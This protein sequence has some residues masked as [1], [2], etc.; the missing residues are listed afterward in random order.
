MWPTPA[1]EASVASSSFIFKS[2]LMTVNGTLK[3]GLP[4]PFL[5]YTLTVLTFEVQHHKTHD[6][7]EFGPNIRFQMEL[8]K[9]KEATLENLEEGSAEPVTLTRRD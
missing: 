2:E 6:R 8:S 1:V 4:H 3:A 7:P 9:S 5:R